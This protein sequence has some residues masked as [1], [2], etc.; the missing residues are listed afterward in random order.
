M[1]KGVWQRV[2]TKLGKSLNI[3]LFACFVTNTVEK[4]SKND[5]DLF[6]EYTSRGVP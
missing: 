6:I 5:V 3:C 2:N 4:L 1:L